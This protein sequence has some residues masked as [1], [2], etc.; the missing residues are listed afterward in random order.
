[1]YFIFL[2][3]LL[4]SYKGFPCGSAGKE[5]A[6]NAGDLGLIAGLGRSPREEKGYPLQASGPENSMD[7]IVHGVAKSQTQLSKFHSSTLSY[8]SPKGE[9]LCLIFFLQLY[10]TPRK[11]LAQSTHSINIC[12]RME[13]RKRRKAGGL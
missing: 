6:C 13:R 3:V 12:W 10:L 4:L 7:H 1:M 11:F 9:K 5:F 2:L 8:E